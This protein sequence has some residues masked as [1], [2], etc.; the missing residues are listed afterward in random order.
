MN[1]SREKLFRG[2]A[3]LHS[4]PECED[5]NR[6]DVI[7]WLEF[8]KKYNIGIQVCTNEILQSVNNKTLDQEVDE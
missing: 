8:D 1:I 2:L 6:T 7:D 4:I 3:T 5:R